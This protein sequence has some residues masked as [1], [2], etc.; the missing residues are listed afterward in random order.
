M[1]SVSESGALAEG[2]AIWFEAPGA[3]AGGATNVGL[4]AMAGT[5]R[6][7]DI[8]PFGVVPG[9]SIDGGDILASVGS[10]RIGTVR[11]FFGSPSAA[12]DGW[13]IDAED[14]LGGRFGATAAA[15]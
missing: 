15:H 13:A 14:E 11:T 12:E 3:R 8:L 7:P 6:E 9:G 10:G 1:S 4:F 5:A 2:G